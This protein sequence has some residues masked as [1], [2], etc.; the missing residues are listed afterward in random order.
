MKL[1]TILG[2]TLIPNKSEEP[3]VTDDEL[4]ALKDGKEIGSIQI[5]RENS[6]NIFTPVVAQG[7]VFVFGSEH[8]NI[9]AAVQELL[10]FQ[11]DTSP[12]AAAPGSSPEP[13]PPIYLLG[14]QPMTCP[15]CGART[16]YT[17]LDGGRQNHTCLGCGFAFI[18][19]TN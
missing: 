8:E 11:L 18:A 12:P 14:D 3:D 15:K 16:E 2:V 7:N 6:R 9:T 17:E 4:T 5:S 19:S 1:K 13:D 10:T